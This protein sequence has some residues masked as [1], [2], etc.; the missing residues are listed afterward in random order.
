[1]NFSLYIKFRKWHRRQRP[2]QRSGNGKQYNNCCNWW[3]IVANKPTPA[4]Q[5]TTA[6]EAWPS[7]SQR[8]AETSKRC[9][10]FDFKTCIPTVCTYCVAAKS[11]ELW[12]T[13]SKCKFFYNHFDFFLLLLFSF[14]FFTNR[15]IVLCVRW[16]K[17]SKMIITFTRTHWSVCVN[18]LRHIWFNCSKMQNYSAF[19]GLMSRLTQ[20]TCVSHKFSVVQKIQEQNEI[21]FHLHT[22]IGSQA[23]FSFVVFA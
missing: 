7:C 15:F 10:I 23:K 9:Q 20:K 14:L 13:K 17:D 1:M 2:Q 8:N 5:A 6:E 18:R 22:S 21:D 16:C 19:I 3:C 11:I 4:T 12:T